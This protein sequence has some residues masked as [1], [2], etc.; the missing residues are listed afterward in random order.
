MPKGINYSSEEL[1]CFLDAVE[2]LL[3]ISSTAWGHV[4]KIHMARYPDKALTDCKHL[5]DIA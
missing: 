5:R 4:A 2:D 1:D 3:P